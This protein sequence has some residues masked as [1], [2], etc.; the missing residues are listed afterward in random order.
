VELPIYMDHNATTPVDPRVIE[1]MLPAFTVHFGNPAS[2]T[3]A[4]G[5]AAARLVE[6]S[7]ERIADALGAHP[8]EVIFTSGA[9][10]SDNLAIK[11]VAWALAG[12]GRHL[13]TVATEHKAV[14][15][16]CSASRARGSRSRCCR[17]TGTAASSPSRS[18]RR[19]A[20]TPCS[21]R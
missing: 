6:R 5:W 7:R 18:R 17:S 9:T 21:C 14:L 12:R 19:C 20:A 3:H 15:D 10:E 8:D 4:Y 13:I 11:G 16:P 1:A 2:R